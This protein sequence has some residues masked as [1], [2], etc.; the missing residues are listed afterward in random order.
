MVLRNIS[1]KRR[2]SLG[3]ARSEK[4]AFSCVRIIFT[5]D[6]VGLHFPTHNLPKYILLRSSEHLD[7]FSSEV[8]LNLEVL[9]QVLVTYDVN[10]LTI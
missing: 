8:M 6:C 10:F 9:N 4:S 5:C 2:F 7:I 1:G 3:Q